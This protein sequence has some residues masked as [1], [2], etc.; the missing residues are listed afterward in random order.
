VRGSGKFREKKKKEVHGKMSSGYSDLKP[1]VRFV[2]S[3]MG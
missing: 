2:I 3:G 1:W